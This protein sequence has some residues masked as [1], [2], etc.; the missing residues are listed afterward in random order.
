MPLVEGGGVKDPTPPNNH[1]PSHRCLRS[2]MQPHNSFP[3]ISCQ[4][5]Q[6]VRELEQSGIKND[7]RTHPLGGGNSEVISWLKRNDF[8]NQEQLCLLASVVH[9]RSFIHTADISAL[10]DDFKRDGEKNGVVQP[11]SGA[12][13]ALSSYN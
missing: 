6:S 4:K 5:A 13:Q 8:Y 9:V 11:Y 12:E 1:S 3:Y 7:N 2:T 10:S